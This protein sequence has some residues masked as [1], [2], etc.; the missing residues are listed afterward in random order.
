MVKLLW[1]VK[2]NA[3]ARFR[4]FIQ[5]SKTVFILPWKLKDKRFLCK[6]YIFQEDKNHKKYHIKK[7]C[8]A[9]FTKLDLFMHLSVR[10]KNKVMLEKYIFGYFL[11][12]FFRRG[13]YII[14]RNFYLY[15]IF[16]FIKMFLT[17]KNVLG[18]ESN[19][20]KWNFVLYPFS[21]KHK[22]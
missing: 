20:F 6:K 10:Y 21:F 17:S 5:L 22:E 19:N 18:T 15:S 9:I 13:I 1:N 4:Y 11:W 7:Y 3:L 8:Y 14:F 12:N 2:N 16:W